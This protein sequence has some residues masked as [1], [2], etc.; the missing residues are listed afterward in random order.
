MDKFINDLYQVF[1]YD[2]NYLYFV[3]GIG[4]TLL[5]TVLALI[6]G[7]VIGVVVAIIRASPSDQ[8]ALRRGRAPGAGRVDGRRL[9][10]STFEI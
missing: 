8:H 10:E 3:K 7:L 4:I 6:L 5:V 9:P 1:V 2:N